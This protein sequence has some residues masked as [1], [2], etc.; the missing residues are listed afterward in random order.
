MQ[1]EDHARGIVR[2]LSLGLRILTLVE[3][4]V[5]EALQATGETLSGLYASNPKW[6]T[7]HPTTERP[8]K[9]FHGITLTVIHLPDQ[10][11]RHVTPLSELQRRIVALLGLPASIYENQALYNTIPPWCSQDERTMG[12]EALF[13]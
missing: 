8:L 9:A 7:A 6:Q 1:R 2:L 10:T 4:V 5:R 13:W 3:H 11:I 12:K